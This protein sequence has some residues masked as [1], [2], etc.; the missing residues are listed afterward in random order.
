MD[1]QFPSAVVATGPG[2]CYVP[3][4]PQTSMTRLT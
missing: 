3:L 1:G 2:W 4:L